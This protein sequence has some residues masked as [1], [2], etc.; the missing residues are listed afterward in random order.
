V[1]VVVVGPFLPLG[2]EGF[3]EAFS[4]DPVAHQRLNLVPCVAAFSRFL[5][6]N[7]FTGFGLLLP[8]ALCGFHTNAS[9]S[10]D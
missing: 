1:V 6:N 8:L 5:K 9:F 3:F 2:T 7:L 10:L 4:S